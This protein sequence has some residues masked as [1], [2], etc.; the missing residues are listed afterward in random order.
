MVFIKVEKKEWHQSFLDAGLGFWQNYENID[1]TI[2]AISD[3]Y[4]KY[5]D[6]GTALKLSD[7]IIFK[8]WCEPDVNNSKITIEFE[9]REKLILRTIEPALFDSNSELIYCCFAKG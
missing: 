4:F 5:I 1:P 7:K 8:I 3:D 9:S 6:R 2:E